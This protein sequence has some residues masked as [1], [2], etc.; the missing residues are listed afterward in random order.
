MLEVLFTLIKIYLLL[1]PFGQ[2]LRIPTYLP[3]VVVHLADVVV[4]I[5]ALFSIPLWLKQRASPFKSPLAFPVLLFASVS[6]ISLLV[7]AVLVTWS[8]FLVGAVYWARWIAYANLYFLVS[9]LVSQS[10]G[11]QYRQQL[12][13]T[14]KFSGFTLAVFGFIQYLIFPNL[15]LIH[16]QGWDVHLYRLTGPIFDPGFTGLLL[17]FTL[18]LIFCNSKDIKLKSWNFLFALIVYVALVLTYSWVTYLAL[19][20]TAVGYLIVR[21]SFKTA[22]VFLSIFLV[23]ALLIP[24]PP[25][26]GGNLARTS[27][28]NYRFTNWQQSLRVAQDHPILGVGFDLYRYAQTRYGFLT[29][30]EA[31][32]SHSA[33]GVDNSFLFILATTGIIGLFIF[34]WLWFSIL[35]FHFPL[36]TLSSSL[37]LTSFLTVVAALVHNQFHNTLFYPSIMAWIWIILGLSHGTRNT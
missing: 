27:T 9:F 10:S 26:E 24:R 32:N 11:D 4:L 25:G 18:I 28:V 30:V 19:I 20:A 21:R 29:S 5:V 12:L 37:S 35:K 31:D 16:T 23:T 1:V 7:G 14:L 33:A 8:Q 15:N 13:Q 3:E 36:T 17:L 22:F 34:I 6:L 2:L